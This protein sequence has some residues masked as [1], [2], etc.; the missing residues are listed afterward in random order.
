MVRL[1]KPKMNE[2]PKKLTKE[3]KEE[4]QRQMPKLE[5]EVK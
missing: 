3:E 1:K 5:K 4:L 2:K